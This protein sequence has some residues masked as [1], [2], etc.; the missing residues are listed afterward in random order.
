[1]NWRTRNTPKLDVRYMSA[2]P[3]G[4]LSSP[5]LREAEIDRDDRDLRREHQPDQHDEEQA[6]AAGKLEPRE[7]EGGE[8]A[9]DELAD[10]HEDRDLDAVGVD[11]QERH[12]R[13]RAP[14]G[15]C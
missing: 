1:M 6:V 13:I 4:L 2:S 3:I 12:D 15:S 8:R 11:L 7:G 10:R 9:G 5:T 14:R